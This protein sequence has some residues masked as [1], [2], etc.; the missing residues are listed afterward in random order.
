[1]TI[2]FPKTILFCL[3]NSRA[4]RERTTSKS[5]EGTNNCIAIQK[6]FGNDSEKG[7]KKRKRRKDPE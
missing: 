1:M 3:G 7:G 4:A 2:A 6:P 5:G